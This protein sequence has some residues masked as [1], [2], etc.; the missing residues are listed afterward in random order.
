MVEEK[1]V[2]LQK[3]ISE[4]D[5]YKRLLRYVF[6]PLEDGNLLF[7]ND[8]MIREGYGRTLTYPPDVKYTEQ[9]LEAQEQA[10]AENRG[11][12]GKCL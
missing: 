11:L 8:Y 6:L 3:D 5:K 4:T 10:K 1:E 12:W 9:F 7:I 2:I